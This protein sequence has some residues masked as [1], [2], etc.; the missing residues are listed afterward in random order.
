VKVENGEEKAAAGR[1]GET[2]RRELEIRKVKLENGE[3]KIRTLPDG[4]PTR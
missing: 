2:G 4:V 3:E 1:R